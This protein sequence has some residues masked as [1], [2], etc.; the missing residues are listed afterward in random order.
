MWCV[1]KDWD[2]ES[3]HVGVFVDADDSIVLIQT[4]EAV[5]EVTHDECWPATRKKLQEVWPE[6]LNTAT[7]VLFEGEEAFTLEVECKGEF[8]PG[9][10]VK[11]DLHSAWC[12]QQ[13]I[14]STEDWLWVWSP[15][16][17][18]IETHSIDSVWIDRAEGP[19]A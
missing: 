19:N 14:T 11:L 16:F 6:A 8:L 17:R 12:N 10:W 15:K 5:L 18:F 4:A 2:S 9:S 1:V 7:P 3:E 13:V